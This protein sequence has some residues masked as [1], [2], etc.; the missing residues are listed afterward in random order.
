[1]L[2][3]LVW[4]CWRT[5][6][7]TIGKN[8]FERPRFKNLLGPERALEGETPAMNPRKISF[9]ALFARQNVFLYKRIFSYVWIYRCALL[10]A[11]AIFWSSAR[12]KYQDD[13]NFSKCRR[14]LGRASLSLL[15]HFDLM[16]LY[17]LL[18]N[19]RQLPYDVAAVLSSPLPSMH[20]PF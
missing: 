2:V 16:S 19:I 12:E 9:C 1:V 8:A 13:G 11:G 7:R 6:R 4:L 10:L 18:Y 3:W 20:A 5:S 14:L 17:L 15:R